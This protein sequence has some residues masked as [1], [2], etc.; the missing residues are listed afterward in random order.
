MAWS[1]E[2]FREQYDK[3]ASNDDLAMWLHRLAGL[4]IETYRRRGASGKPA[5]SLRRTL[6]PAPFFAVRRFDHVR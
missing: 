3:L 5:S 4:R 6:R 1:R 2:T